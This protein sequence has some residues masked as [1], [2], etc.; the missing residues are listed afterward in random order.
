MDAGGSWLRC[1]RKN[2]V[3]G[4]GVPCLCHTG[5]IDLCFVLLYT[6]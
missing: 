5:V 3:F 6:K 4:T 1:D 2:T